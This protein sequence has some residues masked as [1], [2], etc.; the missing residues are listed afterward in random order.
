MKLPGM[1][2]IA[3]GQAEFL[4]YRSGKLW[5]RLEWRDGEGFE[6]F[7]FPIPLDDAGD[8]DFLPTMKG[9]NLMRWARKHVDLLKLAGIGGEA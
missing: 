9:T 7:D 6:F 2:N 8:G 3:K 1:L 4:K 5:Y